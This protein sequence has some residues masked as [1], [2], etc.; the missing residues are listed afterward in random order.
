[1]GRISPA[2]MSARGEQSAKETGAR[3]KWKCAKKEDD[4]PIHEYTVHGCELVKDV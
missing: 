1:M 4:F 3:I 2:L